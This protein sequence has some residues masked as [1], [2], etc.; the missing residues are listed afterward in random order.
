MSCS[1][2]VPSENSSGKRTQRGGITRSG[3]AHLRRI[4]GEAAWSYR[5]K[6]A[7]GAALRKRQENVPEE[8][9]QMAW[10]AQIRLSKRYARLA[11]NGKD[12]RKIVTA[13]GRELLGFVWAIGVW[14][15]ASV[16]QQRAA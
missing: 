8:I 11:A 5:R 1:G 2:A 16:P 4:L 3:N 9:R 12:Q 14:V 6:P 13:V 7:V 15:E 10:K